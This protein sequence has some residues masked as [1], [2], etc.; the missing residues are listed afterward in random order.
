MKEYLLFL[1]MIFISQTYITAQ[2][3]SVSAINAKAEAGDSVT[4]PIN[5]SGFV[6]VGAITIKLQFDPGVLAFGRALN[7]DSQIPEAMAG[8][9]NGIVTIAWDGL[10]GVNKSGGSLVELRFLYIGG[11]TSLNF[12]P[13]SEI[14]DVEANPMQV[15]YINGSIKKKEPVAAPGNLRAEVIRAYRINLFWKDNSDNESGFYIYRKDGEISGNGIYKLIGKA[16]PNDTTFEDA[17]IKALLT[18]TYKVCAF[19]ADSSF[20]YSNEVSVANNLVSV[21]ANNRVPSDYKLYQNYPNP[22]NP[23]TVIKYNLKNDCYV[24]LTVF[25]TIG[26]EVAVLVNGFRQPGMN[27][28]TFNASEMPSGIYFYKIETHEENGS[29]FKVMKKMILIK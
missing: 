2:N 9:K 19:N 26:T 4:I 18:Y 24:K 1:F 10:T 22:F 8:E 6:N 25:N 5:V 23:S 27:S 15:T 21:A 20:S 16:A 17:A 29:S 14:A 7:W 3:V 11:T 12:L 28:V 13:Q